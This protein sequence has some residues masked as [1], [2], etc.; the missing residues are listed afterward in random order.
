MKGWDLSFLS[1]AFLG[2][3]LV[4]TTAAAQ[5]PVH[6]ASRVGDLVV[7]VEDHAFLPAF[8]TVSVGTTLTW[9]NLD[10]ELHT[11]TSDDGV[12]NGSVGVNET[13]SLAFNEPG[14]FF[15]YCQP[16]DWMIGEVTVVDG[17]PAE[18]VL[19]RGLTPGA[20]APPS[21]SNRGLTAGATVLPS[22]SPGPEPSPAAR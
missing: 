18:R 15:Y 11:V 7:K 10:P 17:Q 22:V 16:H 1:S 6:P 14:I 12:F 13:F 19:D 5:E 21:V 2:V 20:A 3:T 4:V 9:T 8:V